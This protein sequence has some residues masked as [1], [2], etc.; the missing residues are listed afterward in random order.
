MKYLLIKYGKHPFVV[1]L[2]LASVVSCIILYV[3]LEWLD[4]YT[5]H[6]KA[7]IV[8][9]VRGLQVEK[10]SRFLYSSGLRYNVIDSVFSKNVKPGAIVEILPAVGSKVKTGRIIFIT[11]NAFSSQ[12]AMIPEVKD[13]SF[14]QAHAMLKVRGFESIEIEYV[15][16]I[17]KDL[18]VGVEL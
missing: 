17:Y 9:D 7:V 12:M 11:V 14:R 2:L 3:T 4:S 15:S 1:N 8:P 6:N 5:L 16:G 18:V 13:V 10:A